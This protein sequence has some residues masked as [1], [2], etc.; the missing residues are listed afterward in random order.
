[1]S[2]KA[3]NKTLNTPEH[4]RLSLYFRHP[5]LLKT[6][7]WL[8]GLSFI[9]NTGIVWA[10][11]RPISGSKPVAA[12]K[13]TAHSV[14]AASTPA[15]LSVPAVSP[16]QAVERASASV[17][18]RP[19]S[20]LQ[21]TNVLAA[22][23]YTV[24]VMANNVPSDMPAAVEIFVPR[25]LSSTIPTTSASKVKPKFGSKSSIV[26]QSVPAT[27]II[28][29]SKPT[30]APFGGSHVATPLVAVPTPFG[31][32]S[33]STAIVP[34][35]QPSRLGVPRAGQ[36][37]I[38]TVQVPTATT[39]PVIQNAV[40][41]AVPQLPQVNKTVP[42][43]TSLPTVSPT[44]SKPT[45]VNSAGGSAGYISADLIYPL[46]TPAPTTS[47][48]GWRTH[49][50]TGKRRFHSGV[51]IGAP[52][53]A[54]VVAAASGTVVS[55]GWQGGYGKAIVIQHNGVQ[56]TLYGH[57]SEVFVQPGQTI[58]QGIVIGRVGSTGNSTGPHLHFEARVATSDGWVATDPG[59]DIQYALENL[60][61]AMPTAQRDVP[62]GNN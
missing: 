16:L 62:T 48:F 10:D 59:A 23:N 28:S 33:K 31:Q 49:P 57:L 18:E 13:E 21:H 32:G 29:K 35:L 12:A 4:Q 24:G 41:P 3:E 22:D 54:P 8:G 34:P 50:I 44:A 36:D 25:P 17:T 45:A 60:R 11:F 39:R 46:S 51:D 5:V 52:M 30:A 6:V 53:G 2:S 47:K 1:M 61:R 26:T 27:G 14:V 40:V 56:Q 43:V 19:I 58:E 9:G 38:P 42:T 37:R 7:A 55:A 15:Q 20:R